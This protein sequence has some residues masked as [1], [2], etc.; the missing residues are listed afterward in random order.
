MIK[1]KNKHSVFKYCPNTDLPGTWLSG[2]NIENQAIKTN[3][4][5]GR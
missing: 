1:A 3:K 5:D 4:T 2:T